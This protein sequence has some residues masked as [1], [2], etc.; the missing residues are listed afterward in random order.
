MRDTAAE[1]RRRRAERAELHDTV[2]VLATMA[3]VG[4]VL[5]VLLLAGSH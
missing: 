3:A 5:T 4:I 2:A 1:D